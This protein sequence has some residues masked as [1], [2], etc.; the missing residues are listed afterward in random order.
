MIPHAMSLYLDD[1][2]PKGALENRVLRQDGQCYLELSQNDR[3]LLTRLGI[4]PDNLGPFL[5]ACVWDEA[6]ALEIGG[7][8]IIDNLSMGSPAMGGIRMLP[9]IQPLDIYNLARGMTL[10]NGAANLP[11]GGGKAGI[12]APEHPVA[13]SDREGIIRGFA[14]LLRRYTDRY[15][16]GPDVGTNDQDMKI[17]AVENGIDSAV[18]KTADMGGNRID[19]LGGAAGGVIIALET[20][21]RIMPR[22]KVL[23][24]FND[25]TIPEDQNISVLFQG[26][27]AVGAHAARLLRERLPNAVTIGVSDRDGYLFDPEGLPVEA[28]FKDWQAHG[29]VT[30]SHFQK[31]LADETSGAKTTFSNAADNLLRESAFCLVPAASV[32][33]YLGVD[34]DAGVS[35]TVERM[36]TWRVIV[37]GA[38]TYSPDPNIRAQRTRMEQKVYAD[39][40]ILIA[41]DYLVNSG[42]VIF[43]AQEHLIPTPDHL[44]IPP[45]LLGDQDAVDTWLHQHVDEF[46]ALSQKRKVAGEQWREEVI[47]TNMIE[48]VNLL[49]SDASLLP[50][51]AAERVSLQRLAEREEGRTAKDIMIEVPRVHADDAIQDA[52]ARIVESENNLAVVLGDD[53]QLV[54]VITS[55]DITKAIAEVRA[56]T[57]LCVEQLMRHQSVS[58]TP[59]DTVMQVLSKLEENQISAVPVVDDG[60]V[61]GMINSDL[62][63]YRYLPRF[64]TSD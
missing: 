56:W 21:L 27:G 46:T 60:R 38:N 2:L 52:A 5:V 37:E 10:K 12:V 62:L 53:H 17:V 19:E 11:Y 59:H 14:R 39:K 64:L 3:Q 18:S 34:P 48:V 44:Q 9:S 47:Q 43:A 50:C 57:E 28:L 30:K 1:H 40:G 61:L 6:S 55:W 51:Q 32:F 16:P 15:V 49:T 58:V 33:N 20:L 24:Q 45:H 41:T 8:V 22:L 35:M 23:S 7:Y 54:G 4:T 36:G 25:L 31:V 29:L 26:F 63:A 13:S 42:G